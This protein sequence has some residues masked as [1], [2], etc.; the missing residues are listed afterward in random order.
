MASTIRPLTQEVF[1]ATQYMP[2]ALT[3]GSRS[4][5]RTPSQRGRAAGWGG[6][7]ENHDKQQQQY[8]RNVR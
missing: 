3:G 5:V 2:N 6:W 4:T 7:P 8:A 1:V